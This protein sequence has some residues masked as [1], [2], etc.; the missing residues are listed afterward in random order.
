VGRDGRKIGCPD[1]NG[2]EALEKR[3]A[4]G[5]PVGCDETRQ[6]SQSS[7]LEIWIGTFQQIKEKWE[8]AFLG[9]ERMERRLRLL[10]ARR[11]TNGPDEHLEIREVRHWKSECG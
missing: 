7:A 3:V 10:D 8:G 9:Q 11:A 5:E 4:G 6:E 2:P 1:E